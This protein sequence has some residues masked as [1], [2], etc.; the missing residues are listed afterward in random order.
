MMVT[1]INLF[2]FILRVIGFYVLLYFLYKLL[3][4]LKLVKPPESSGKEET[5]K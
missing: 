1:I 5:K 3:I 2:R 4:L